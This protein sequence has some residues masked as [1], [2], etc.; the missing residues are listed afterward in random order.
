MT[1]GILGPGAVG[2]YLAHEF[3]RNGH[4]V[5]VVGKESHVITIKNRGVVVVP[6][7][8]SVSSQTPV[9][10][11]AVAQLAEKVSLLFITVK[12]PHLVDSL[13]R[14]DAGAVSDAVV[15]PL[16]N[17]IGHAE[18][19]RSALG[20]RV[21]VGTIGAVEVSLQEPGI[22]IELSKQTPH[23]DL[24]S[25]ADIPL[26]QLQEIAT[27]LI[28]I[29]ISASVEHS[30]AEVIWKKLTRLNAIASL[31]ALFQVPIGEIREKEETR[32]L[33]HSVVEETAR[34]AQAD[35]VSIDATAVLQSIEQLPSGLTT[36]LQRDI[37]RNAESELDSIT[38]GV[39]K[40]A[41]EY[42]IPCPRLEEVYERLRVKTQSG[43]TKTS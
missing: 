16:L 24:A 15:I 12:G 17:G 39:L 7:N 34:V 25:D 13:H 8:E 22:V 14:I 11:D 3:A 29:G 20:K 9:R 35:G 32:A 5:I 2:T 33:L 28:S 41:R 36:S 1:I 23:V 4:D 30:E 6:M 37:R 38:G 26:N 10:V 42:G 43:I 31:T 40:K 19:V 21:A 18:T 27:L